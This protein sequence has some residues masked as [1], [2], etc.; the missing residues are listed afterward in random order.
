MINVDDIVK[1][2]NIIEVCPVFGK[3]FDEDSHICS[4]CGILCGEYQEACRAITI[5]QKEV[6][7]INISAFI[8]EL[9]Y[10]KTPYKNTIY[11]IANKLIEIGK[12]DSRRKALHS[13]RTRR[14]GIVQQLKKRKEKGEGCR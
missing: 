7:S 6:P 12:Y 13:A 1:R 9:I 11:S 14:W 4:E 3:S 2:N 5:S 10:K 8:R